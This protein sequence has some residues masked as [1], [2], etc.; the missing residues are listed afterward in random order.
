[1]FDDRQK[2]QL[3]KRKHMVLGGIV[4]FILFASVMMGIGSGSIVVGLLYGIFC[5][6]FLK[7]E[8]FPAFKDYDSN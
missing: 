1:M 6:L 3:L 7:I 8:M 5:L 2:K 4:L